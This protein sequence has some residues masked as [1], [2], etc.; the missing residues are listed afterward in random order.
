MVYSK[1]RIGIGRMLLPGLLCCGLAVTCQ[2]T[3][4]F[5][6]C[7]DHVINSGAL[8]GCTTVTSISMDNAL[9]YIGDSAFQGCTNLVS[10]SWG[11]N[12]LEIG[13]KA[14]YECRKVQE[15]ILPSKLKV[16]KLEAFMVMDSLTKLV[17][18]ECI[19]SLGYFWGLSPLCAMSITDTGGTARYEVKNS[20]YLYTNSN[21]YWKTF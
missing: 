14:F 8:K 4:H 18:P 20:Y 15:M 19:E 7:Y 13:Q 5:D 11:S 2:A 6:D 12:I 9:E 17:F 21:T 10:I 16:I 1:N 3:V